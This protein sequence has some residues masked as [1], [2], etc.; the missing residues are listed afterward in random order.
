MT[1][2]IIKARMERFTRIA[3]LLAI[4]VSL[5][6]GYYFVSS[7]YLLAVGRMRLE[8]LLPGLLLTAFVIG[9]LFLSFRVI[10]S[11]RRDCSPF[12]LAN[13]R[14]LRGIGLLLIVY[15]LLQSALSSVMTA[16]MAKAL[17]TAGEQVSVHISLGGLLIVTGLAVFSLS[18]VF[19]Y[20]VQLQQLSD[21]T[22]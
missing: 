6:Y 5:A 4:L 12:T 18:Y 19:Q 15:D 1:Q 17:S 16:S 20:G 13:A 22:L 2:E 11:L 8:A 14:R 3:K 7:V 21:E 9:I 10:F